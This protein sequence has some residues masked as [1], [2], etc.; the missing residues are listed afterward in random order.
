M[1]EYFQILTNMPQRRSR[2]RSLNDTMEVLHNIE[3]SIMGLVRRQLGEDIM[4]R[5]AV[6]GLLNNFAVDLVTRINSLE[7]RLRVHEET[8][9]L[10]VERHLD[11][12][13]YNVGNVEAS[14]SGHRENIEELQERV[15]RLETAPPEIT[16][17]EQATERIGSI[18]ARLRRLE[19]ERRGRDDE[20]WNR[21]ISVR[22]FAGN[23]N[24]RH[25]R[26]FDYVKYKLRS[27]GY[28]DVIE[29]TKGFF[30]SRN[31]NLRLEFSSR[32]EALCQL[33]ELRRQSKALGSTSLSFEFSVPPRMVPDKKRLALLGMRLK[34]SQ[35]LDNFEIR[36]V[37]TSGGAMLRMKTFVKPWNHD[38]GT[39]QL[40]PRPQIDKF[41]SLNDV[42]RME[43]LLDTVQTA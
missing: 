13:S 25:N 5:D 2:T 21:C 37:M 9:F 28:N 29:N 14:V 22:K 43:E 12:N 16:N 19:E 18:D 31:G 15:E 38:Y 11:N 8:T 1:K 41:L 26:V 33:Q 35:Y 3:E 20:Y 6:N 23:I 24:I 40:G 7:E 36:C 17:N 32:M 30:L 34:R 27:Y 4:S 10:T 39:P 42:N